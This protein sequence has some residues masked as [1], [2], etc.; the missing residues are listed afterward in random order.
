MIATGATQSALTIRNLRRLSAGPDAATLVPIAQVDA[1]WQAWNSFRVAG[2][3]LSG[4]LDDIHDQPDAAAEP[5]DRELARALSGDAQT[6]K[7]TLVD[8]EAV[9][10]VT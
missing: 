3:A 8:R 1:A 4:A 2:A 9:A 10:T 6:A 7:R 5:I